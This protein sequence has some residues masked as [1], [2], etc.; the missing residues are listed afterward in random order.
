MNDAAK[1]MPV[2]AMTIDEFLVWAEGDETI[3]ELIDGF[4]VPKYGEWQGGVV[5]MSPARNRHQI[6]KGNACDALKRQLKLP[7]RAWEEAAIRNT[8]DASRFYVADVA[9][10]CSSSLDDQY[11]DAPVMV[12]EVLSRGTQHKDLV[13]KL[14]FYLAHPSVRAIV[15]FWQDQKRARVWVHESASDP[16]GDG[17]SERVWSM[18]DVIGGHAIEIALLGVSISLDE[19]YEGLLEG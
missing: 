13:D 15:Y 19:V 3:Y 5:A 12:I 18:R 11:V 16:A 7:C 8:S 1:S 17:S 6:M 2:K 14:A 4:P 10:S 9:V